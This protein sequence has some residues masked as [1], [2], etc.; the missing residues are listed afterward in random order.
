MLG[1][2]GILAPGGAAVLTG[3]Q[4]AAAAAYGSSP[5]NPARA[6]AGGYL[7]LGD[8]SPLSL[9]G[10]EWGFVPEENLRG[11]GWL[12]VFPPQRWKVIR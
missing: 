6:P 4:G 12:V 10:R 2:D 11:R 8:N 9:D 7:M 1:A 5:D 3:E